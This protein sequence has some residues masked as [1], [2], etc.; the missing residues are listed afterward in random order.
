MPPNPRMQPTGPTGAKFLAESIRIG[1]SMGTREGL[2]LIATLIE[3]WVAVADR[4]PHTPSHW[5]ALTSYRCPDEPW[6]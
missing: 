4:R 2:R 1:E 3:R 5:A 6:E